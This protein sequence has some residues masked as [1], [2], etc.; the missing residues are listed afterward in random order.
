MK[1]AIEDFNNRPHRV[2]NGLTPV[3]VLDGKIFDLINYKKQ[4]TISKELRL[5]ENRIIKCCSYTF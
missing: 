3:E 4:I 5:N 2:L 1:E